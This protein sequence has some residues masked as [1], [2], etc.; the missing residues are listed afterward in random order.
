[1]VSCA[2]LHIISNE[3][4]RNPVACSEATMKPIEAPSGVQC[5]ASHQAVHMLQDARNDGSCL[6]ERS[7]PQNVHV[8]EAIHAS[9][10][11]SQQAQATFRQHAAM[12]EGSA[13][14]DPI[15]QESVSRA[16]NAGMAEPAKPGP[17][18]KVAHTFPASCRTSECHGKGQPKWWD[19]KGG[20]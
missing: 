18:A 13:F 2:C 16:L 6:E 1:M 17:T 7:A 9:L 3:V 4:F 19:A 8:Q 10:D 11:L 20:A 15:F 14:A 12:R 5:A